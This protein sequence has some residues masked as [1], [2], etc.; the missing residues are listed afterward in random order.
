MPCNEVRQ[1]LK[2]VAR[3]ENALKDDHRPPFPVQD[4]STIKPAGMWLKRIELF[5]IR[6]YRSPYLIRIPVHRRL[7]AGLIDNEPGL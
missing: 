3:V 2:N 7:P 1:A 5:T 4:S 6:H